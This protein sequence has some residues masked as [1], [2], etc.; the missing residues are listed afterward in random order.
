MQSVC[1]NTHNIVMNIRDIK[2]KIIY[3]LQLMKNVLDKKISK[4]IKKDARNKWSKCKGNATDPT[5]CELGSSFFN[6][7]RKGE[8]LRSFK[9]FLW[10]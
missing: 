7:K 4:S 3:C 8:I 5:Q 1:Q 10:Q 9:Y 6:K 2:E